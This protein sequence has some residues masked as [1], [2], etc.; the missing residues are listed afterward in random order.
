M[1][2]IKSL[3]RL[4][5]DR[6]RLAFMQL[7]LSIFFGATTFFIPYLPMNGSTQKYT[8]GVVIFVITI[9]M[10]SKRSTNHILKASSSCAGS[11]SRA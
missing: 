8:G 5:Q 9:L 4:L 10:F 1:N 7:G 2:Y 6:S 11:S 3:K